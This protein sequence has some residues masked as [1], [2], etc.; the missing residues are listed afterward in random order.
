[1]GK[2]FWRGR[3][4]IGRAPAATP[5]KEEYEA[6][7]GG[8]RKMTFTE[9]TAQDAARFE[10]VLNKLASYVGTQPWSQSS[11]AAKAMGKLLDPVLT[12]RTKPVRYWILR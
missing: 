5:N 2:R 9:V 1:M 12:E 3:R 8:L 11:V 10:D 7:T 4:A 6:P